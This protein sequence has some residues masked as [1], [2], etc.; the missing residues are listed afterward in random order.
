MRTC[1]KAPW[2]PSPAARPSLVPASFPKPRQGRLQ[3]CSCRAAAPASR[4]SPR[5]G[6]SATASTRIVCMPDWDRHGGCTVPPQLRVNY[7]PRPSSRRSAGSVRSSFPVTIRCGGAGSVAPVSHR[8]P[9]HGACSGPPGATLRR[10]RTDV[11]GAYD[12]TAAQRDGAEPSPMRPGG[13][14]RTCWPYRRTAAMIPRTTPEA[15]EAR[16]KDGQG[17]GVTSRDPAAAGWGE[18]RASAPQAGLATRTARADAAR[19][20]GEGPGRTPS[21]P[22]SRRF[23]TPPGAVR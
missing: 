9:P 21:M 10:D 11:M 15:A 2:S 3:C 19:L 5:S 16:Y 1:R 20:D 13:R 8:C 14:S 23:G 18:G 6:P 4:K 22:C 7:C 17:P 12:R